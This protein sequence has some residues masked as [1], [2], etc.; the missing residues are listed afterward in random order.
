MRSCAGDTDRR[1][2][3][4]DP[5]PSGP[6]ILPCVAAPNRLGHPL[7]TSALIPLSFEYGKAISVFYSKYRIPKSP[8]LR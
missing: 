1:V 7:L 4:D 5:K 2:P 8:C 6:S 3:T